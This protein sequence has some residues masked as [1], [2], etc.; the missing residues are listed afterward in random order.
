MYNELPYEVSQYAPQVLCILLPR[1]TAGKNRVNRAVEVLD[2]RTATALLYRPGARR[3]R[4][5]ATANA[6]DT[7]FAR[8]E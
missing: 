4:P 8:D 2:Y 7:V 5:L 6:P 1:T 3:A